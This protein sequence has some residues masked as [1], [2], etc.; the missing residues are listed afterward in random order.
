M[1]RPVK[2]PGPEHPI[3]IEP[4]GSRLTVH[5]GGRQVAETGNALVLAEADYPAVYYVPREDVDMSRL[6]RTA[7]EYYCPYKGDA[8][9]YSVRTEAGEVVEDA[10]WS[11][12][13]PFDAVAPIAGHLAFYPQ[14]ATFT[15]EGTA[16]DAAEAG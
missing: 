12:E 5:V 8:T 13:Q 14:H 2:I 16:E 1:S 15:T 3:A 9:F 4:S 11:Y 6:T 7:S 10:V